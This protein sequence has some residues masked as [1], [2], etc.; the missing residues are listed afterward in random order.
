MYKEDV[1]D[2]R[3]KVKLK[4]LNNLPPNPENIPLN[5]STAQG[6]FPSW[7]HRKLPKGGFFKTNSILKKY[8]L[9][10]VCE[11]SKCPNR[12]ECYSKKTATFLALGKEC[13]RS[14]S[15]C[16]IDFSKQP[17]APEVDE[18][19]RIAYTVKELG[20]SHEQYVTE[21]STSEHLRLLS[22]FYF[23]QQN[24][25]GQVQTFIRFMPKCAI[26]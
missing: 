19:E 1:F 16:D 20:L 10:T 26:A 5:D 22:P 6:R 17:K 3:P 2:A 15:F 13:T 8:R 25:T 12:F 14:C 24:G 21:R 9:N 18:P 11:E 4:I 7:L 23:Y